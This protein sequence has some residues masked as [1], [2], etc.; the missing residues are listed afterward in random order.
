MNQV[1]EILL[2]YIAKYNNPSDEQKE[3][4]EKRLE[5]CSGCEFWVQSAIRDYCG[6]CGCT[7]S[8]KVFSPKGADAC[9]EKKWTV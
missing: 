4:A 9:P 5:I 3:I 6:K 8:A 2:S 7:T 1:K